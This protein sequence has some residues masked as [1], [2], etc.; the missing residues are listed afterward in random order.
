[1]K[2]ASMHAAVTSRR[3]TTKSVETGC[4]AS[5]NAQ[6]QELSTQLFYLESLAGAELFGALE[7]TDH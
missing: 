2:M 7:R 6:V 1:M 4:K 5:D 3:R